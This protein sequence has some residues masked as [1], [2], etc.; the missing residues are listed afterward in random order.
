MNEV[1]HMIGGSKLISA[2]LAGQQLGIDVAD[3]HDVI[4]LSAI[5]RV[6][7]APAWVAGVMNLRGRIVAAI[8]LRAR[9]GLPV[10]G[11]NETAMCIVIEHRG[12]PYGLVVDEVG[13]VIDVYPEQVE[14]NPVTLDRRWQQVSDG[15][16]KLDRLMIVASV[17]AIMDTELAE[18]A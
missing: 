6:P 4:R 9:F 10:R 7:R 3:V 8:D 17:A 13:D 14:A 11:A 18:A 15:I 16:V 5:S 2:E 12:E 1:T